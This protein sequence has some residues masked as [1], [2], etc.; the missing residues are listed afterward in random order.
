MEQ[1][2][3]F[4]SVIV[5]SFN[6]GHLLSGTLQSIINQ[7]FGAF[8]VIVVDDGSTDNSQEVV[9]SFSDPRI[10]YFLISNGERAKARN[11]GALQARGVYLN[12]FDSDDLMYPHHLKTAAEFAGANQSPEIFHVGYEIIDDGGNIILQESNFNYHINKRLIKTNFLG[13]NSVFVRKDIFLQ[14][15]FNE[16][17]VLASSEDWEIWLRYAARYKILSCSKITF[18]IR[19][20]SGRSLF[21]LAPERVIQRD[22][23]MVNYL[24]QDKMFTASFNHEIPLFIADRFTFYSLLLSL[25]SRKLQALSFIME[26]LKSSKKVLG[27]RRFWACLKLIIIR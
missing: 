8:E 22:N 27:R 15:K 13:C 5:P 19:N 25:E 4:F 24:L 23:A 1:L 18:A 6:R 9:K 26:A 7:V 2:T 21:N 3:P 12:F 16:D 14:H 10:R 17:R 20:H 11:Y